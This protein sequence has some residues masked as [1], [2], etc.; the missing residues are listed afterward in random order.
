MLNKY[1][2]NLT[3]KIEIRTSN[4]AQRQYIYL[5]SQK[6]N[7]LLRKSNGMIEG[8]VNYSNCDDSKKSL[9][10][11]ANYSTPFEQYHI[12]YDRHI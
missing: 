10:Q 2:W 5:G 7:L 3:K 9:T 12:D 6:F 1:T 8:G 4:F 11:K